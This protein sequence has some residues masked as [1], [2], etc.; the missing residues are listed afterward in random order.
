MFESTMHSKRVVVGTL[1]NTS[2]M[3]MRPVKFYMSHI[4]PVMMAKYH[5]ILYLLSS[6]TPIMQEMVVN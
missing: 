5:T 2:M 4:G 3:N 6:G 1:Q